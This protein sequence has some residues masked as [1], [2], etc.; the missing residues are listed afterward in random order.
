MAMNEAAAKTGLKAD[1]ESIQ[2][3]ID[4]RAQGGFDTM[5]NGQTFAEYFAEQL[6][7][8]I[9]ERM[10]AMIR[11]G[12]VSTNVSVTS[13]SGVMTGPGVSGPGTGSGSGTLT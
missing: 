9:T 7:N 11:T 12:S 4:A 6:A 13:V 5:S 8:K 1:I 2:T 10:A 3:A